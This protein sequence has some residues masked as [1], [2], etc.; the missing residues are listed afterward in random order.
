MW[1]ANKL[2]SSNGL[3]PHLPHQEMQQM[4]NSQ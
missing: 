1:V 2:N 4:H 3:H